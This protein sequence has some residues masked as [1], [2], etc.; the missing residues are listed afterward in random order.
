MWM[1]AETKPGNWFITA[2][3]ASTNKSASCCWRSGLTVNTLTSVTRAWSVADLTP[4]EQRQLSNLLE[5]CTR[6]LGP[7][8]KGAAARS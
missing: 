8:R 2:R 7:A 5:R 3:V 4:G 6:A 1:F